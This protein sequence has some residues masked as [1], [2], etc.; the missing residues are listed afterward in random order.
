MTTTGGPKDRWDKIAVFMAPLGGLLTA[1]AVAG[2]GYDGS[3]LLSRR[4]T[5]ETNARLYSELTSKREESEAALRKD[6]LVSVIQSFLQPSEGGSLDARVLKL[7]LLAY[8]F[9]ES[10]NLKPLFEDVARRLRTLGRPERDEYLERVNRVAREIGSK[11]LFALEGHGR[12]FRRTVDFEELAAAGKAGLALSPEDVELGGRK[13]RVN[14]R[15][16]GVDHDS[17]ELKV[18]LEVQPVRDGASEVDTRATFGVGFFD[19]PLIDNTRLA[20]GQRCALMMTAF[21]KVGAELTGICFPGAY[22]SIK[23]RPYYD[24][25]IQQLRQA[26]ETTGAASP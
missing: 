16:L 25:V 6:M 15:A 17:Q 8:N 19:F 14:L 20:N 22:A 5:I 18:R 10:L 13:F 9:H 1:V 11:Q 3:H 2:V 4:Q 12:S 23:D 26:D 21:G 24:E 7:E